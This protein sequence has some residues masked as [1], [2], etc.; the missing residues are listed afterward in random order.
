VS[1]TRNS[2]L[3][4]HYIT[5]QC[6]KSTAKFG[7]LATIWEPANFR[8]LA[9]ISGPVPPAP[10]RNRRSADFAHFDGFLVLKWRVAAVSGYR[11]LVG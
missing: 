3:T 9:T 6:V 2:T 8:G 11:I 10:A 5:L 4:L 7:G 1:V